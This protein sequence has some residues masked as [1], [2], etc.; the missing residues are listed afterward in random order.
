ML[1]NRMIRVAAFCCLC[2]VALTS[3]AHAQFGRQ[4]SPT[5]GGLFNP[6]IGLGADY[7]MTT[8]KGE[9][10]NFQ[11]AIVGSDTVNGKQGYWM[12]ITIAGGKMPQPMVMKSLSVVDGNSVITQRMIMMINGTA[13]QMPDQMVQGRSKPAETDIAANATKVGTE[14]ITVPAGTFMA[15]HYKNKDGDDFWIAKDAGP[16]G[17]VKMQSHEGTSM[18]LTKVVHDAKD[19][20]TGTPQPFD[21]MAMAR[22]HQ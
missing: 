17:M 5:L 11:M 13:Y 18:V 3:A 7:D 14:S 2:L 6:V 16:W 19:Q 4:Q 12:E 22:Q 9:K 8:S 20:I 1:I 10:M 21:P 15:D